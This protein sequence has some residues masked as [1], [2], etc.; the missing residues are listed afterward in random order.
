MRTCA[1]PGGLAGSQGV[2]GGDTGKTNGTAP[3]MSIIFGMMK[4]YNRL[5]P[6]H[7]GLTAL[8]FLLLVAACGL[9]AWA[10]TPPPDLILTGGRVYTVNPAQSTAEAVAVLGGRILYVGSADSALALRGPATRLL[11]LKGG[12]VLPGLI[13]AHAHLIGLGKFL[14]QIDLIET[15]SPQQALQMVREKQKATPK[16]KWIQGRGWDQNNWGEKRFPSWQDLP[17]TDQNPVYLQR[18]DGHA[19]WINK[20]AMQVCGITRDTPDPEGGKI[21]RDSAGEPTGVFV[22]NAEDLIVAHLPKPSWD[23]QIAWAKTAIAECNRF[24]LVGVHD[25]GADSIA[26]EVYRQLHRDSLLTLRI[27]AMLSPL[28]SS[29]Y[30]HQVAQGPIVDADGRLVI[31]AVKLYADGALGSRGAALLAPYSDDPG[32]KGLMVNKPE[33]LHD[34]SRQAVAHGFQV[35]THAIGDAG[36]RTMLD[37]YERVLREVSPPDPRLRIEHSQVIAQSDIPRFAQLGV[38]PSM[39]PTHATS[40]MRWAEDRLG[41]ERIKGAY[42]WRKLLDQGCRIPFGSD[43]PVESANPL[44]GIYAA[45]TRQDHKGWPAGG[46]Q[47]EER[48]S[49]AEALRGFTIDAAYAE[50]ADWMRGSIEIGKAAD[51]TILDKDICTAPPDSMLTTRVVCT[52]VAGK[53]VYTSTPR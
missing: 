18:V 44:W 46:W 22:D 47:P 28:D 1:R 20:A 51:F 52:I 27:Y 19:A 29:F 40:D 41:P 24:G 21:V 5:A 16:G 14:S 25:A 33:Y 7:P 6:M 49:V 31:A 3:W 39:Q 37:V 12:I 43:F 36:V 38:I 15:T 30:S 53:I 8:V 34:M 48:L 42:A 23:D 4:Y 50:F 17:G 13:D 26:L 9:T 45:V 32:N 11:D 10:A 2:L 35:C